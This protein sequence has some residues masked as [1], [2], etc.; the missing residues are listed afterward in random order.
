ME[1][2][3]LR[4]WNNLTISERKKWLESQSPKSLIELLGMIGEMLEEVENMDAQLAI[5]SNPSADV[6]DARNFTY[7]TLR[8]IENNVIVEL[9]SRENVTLK[10]A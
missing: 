5:L 2:I 3:N 1:Q 10:L 9:C 6:T 8:D 4:D 7:N